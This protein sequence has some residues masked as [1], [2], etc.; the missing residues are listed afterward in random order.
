[1]KQ[2]QRLVLLIFIVP[3]IIRASALHD[4]V[5]KPDDNYAWKIV[6]QEPFERG[7]RY[8]LYMASQAWRTDHDVD[9]TLWRHWLVLNVPNRLDR[10]IALLYIGGGDNSRDLPQKQDLFMDMAVLTRSITAELYNVPNQPLT[11]FSDPD[12][13]QRT[14]DDLLAFAWAE[15]YR[16]HDPE[17]LPLLPMT[18][19]AVRA[20]DT[21]H[22]FSADPNDERK[23]VNRFVVSGASK[24]GWTTWLCA[25]VDKRVIAIAPIVIDA[26]NME[27]SIRHHYRAYG[28]YSEALTP[29]VENRITESF[30]TPR[31]LAAR[32]IM[33]PHSYLRD[34]LIPKCIINSTG[35]RFFLPDSTQF[36]YPDLLGPKYLRYIP[37]TDQGLDETASGTLRS[38]YRAVLRQRPLPVFTWKKPKPGALVVHT[39]TMPR[40]VRL[41]QA[42]NRSAR[43]FRLETI[44]PAWTSRDVIVRQTSPLGQQYAVNVSTPKR[45]W[46][47]FMMELIFDD[48]MQPKGTVTLTTDVTVIPE[49]LPF[50]ELSRVAAQNHR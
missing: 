30:F 21:I 13:R 41:W 50:K 6:T 27:A 8:V 43:D 23:A 4:Y 2:L 11:F 36:Y 49:T 40:R 19:S 26:P 18:K 16:R 10:D 38:F 32:A 31:S 34:I 12:R 45:G 48:P 9:R 14:E 7:T 1:M 17:S 29:Y 25:A 39:K 15:F 46:T 47:A 24:R 22:A 35:D 33:D 37:N 44:G 3:G 28:F 20:M 42:H 5:A